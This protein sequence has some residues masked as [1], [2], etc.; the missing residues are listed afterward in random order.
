MAPNWI[1]MGNTAPGGWKTEQILEEQQM[2]GR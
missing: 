2:R 1:T